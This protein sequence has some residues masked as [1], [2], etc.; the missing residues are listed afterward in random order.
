VV[1]D[2]VQQV[3]NGTM[4]RGYNRHLAVDLFEN[5]KI[6]ETI[7]EGQ[8]KSDKSQAEFN[9]RLGYMG[10]LTLIAEEVVKFAERV[11]PESL[12]QSILDKVTA[13]D[14]VEYVEHIL[15]ETRERDNAILGGVRPDLSLGPRQAV[16]NAVNAGQIGGIG[17][18]LAALTGNSNSLT[19]ENVELNNQTSNTSG[20]IFSG[21]ALM[22]GFNHGSSDEEDEDGD[23]GE[24]ERRTSILDDSDQVGEVSFDDI[25][26]S[27]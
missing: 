9:L 25:E 11:P 26:M 4:E 8:Q 13:P 18:S 12:S 7:I 19:L 1:Y 6:T 14:W 5:A 15:A 3:F 2:V 17:G 10:H 21:S 24:T 22:S 20:Y 27:Y 16:L 23:E